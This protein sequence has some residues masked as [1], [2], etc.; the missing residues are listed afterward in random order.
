[1]R[2]KELNDSIWSYLWNHSTQTGLSQVQVNV[3]WTACVAQ[4]LALTPNS[5]KDPGLNQQ[6][7]QVLTF[8]FEFACS[9]HDCV[10]SLSAL[11]LPPTFDRQYD[12]CVPS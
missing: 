10:G 2:F 11:L 9:P 5:K 8:V 3:S 6:V 12:G 4:W 1:M 7:G